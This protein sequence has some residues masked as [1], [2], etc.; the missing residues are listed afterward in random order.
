MRFLFILF[1]LFLGKSSFSQETSWVIP[2][3]PYYS[4]PIEETGLYSIS[5]ETLENNGI[6]VSSVDVSTFQIFG[7]KEEIPLYFVGDGD[8]LFENGE[9]FVFY[10]QKNDSW[11]DKSLYDDPAFLPNPNVS[12]FNDVIQ[13][14][15]TW[16]N[17]IS[18]KRFLEE[19]DIDFSGL[20]QEKN[21]SVQVYLDF[22]DEY[23]EGKPS[24]LGIPTLNYSN[25]EG[26]S[27]PFIKREEKIFSVQTPNIITST[28]IATV[29]YG[30]VNHSNYENEFVATL[31]GKSMTVSIQESDFLKLSEF[32]STSLLKES[33]ELSINNSAVSVS[34]ILGVSYIMVEYPRDFILPDDLY[35]EFFNRDVSGTNLYQFENFLGNRAFVLDIDNETI[36]SNVISAG[37]VQFKLENKGQKIVVA[38]EKALVPVQ[39]LKK[40]AFSDYE[41]T[42]VDY[43]YVIITTEKLKMSTEEYQEFLISRGFNT[44]VVMVEEL[45]HLFGGGIE[46][47]P[48]AIKNFLD[49]I[50]ENWASPPKH[51][52]LIGKSIRHK[53]S[54]KDFFYENLVP[55]YGSPPSDQLYTFSE[56]YSKA[57]AR[58]SIGRIS[59][60]TDEQVRSY[61]GK[62]K[63]Y[64]TTIKSGWKKNIFHFG[65]GNT[66]EEQKEFAEYLEGYKK[67]IENSKYGANVFTQLKTSSD[68]FDNTLSGFLVEKINTGIGL[69]N[70]FGHGSATGFEQNLDDPENYDNQGKYPFMVANSCY[71]G[72]VHL[73]ILSDAEK[74][75]LTPNRGMIGFIATT[76]LSNPSVL[77]NYNDF[78][79]YFFSET[80]FGEPVGDI[81]KEV[82]NTKKTTFPSSVQFA[83]ERV[84]NDLN[85]FSFFSLQGDPSLPLFGAEYPDFSILSKDI[86]LKN[87]SVS[88]TDDSLRLEIMVSNLGLNFQN[89]I[90]IFVERK[91][92]NQNFVQTRTKNLTVSGFSETF[93]I[94]FP[95]N[96]IESLG[97]NSIRVKVEAKEEVVEENEKN[98]EAIKEFIV[99]RGSYYPFYPPSSSIIPNDS[100]SLKVKT[101]FLIPDNQESVFIMELDTSLSFSSNIKRTFYSGYKN[102]GSILSWNV[103]SLIENEVYYWRVKKNIPQEEWKRS[104]FRYE[105]G[106]TGWS[107]TEYGQFSENTGTNISF[108]DVEKNI[109]FSPFSVELSATA[110]FNNVATNNEESVY[111]INGETQG[112]GVGNTVYE[113]RDQLIVAVIDPITLS[114]W[115]N[116]EYFF[117]ENP[118][119]LSGEIYKRYF[120]FFADESKALKNVLTLLRD[121]VSD[122]HY[123]LLYSQNSPRYSTWNSELISYLQTLGFTGLNSGLGDDKAFV[124]FCEKNKTSS[125]EVALN[126]FE[127]VSLKTNLISSSEKGILESSTFIGPAKNWKNL[128]WD[129]PLLSGQNFSLSFVGLDD[130]FQEYEITNIKDITEKKGEIRFMD[131]DEIQNHKLLKMY[132]SLEDAENRIPPSIQELRIEFD[133][134]PYLVLNTKEGLDFRQNYKTESTLLFQSYVENIASAVVDSDV[135]IPLEYSILRPQDGITFPTEN[136]NL[137]GISAKGKKRIS[138]KAFLGGK[139]YLESNVLRVRMKPKNEYFLEQ[140]IY[141]FPFFVEEAIFNPFVNIAFDGKHIENYEPVRKNVDI[142]FFL[143]DPYSLFSNISFYEAEEEKTY[144]SIPLTLIEK[145]GYKN[146]SIIYSYSPKYEDDKT[147]KLKMTAKSIEGDEIFVEK[148]FTTPALF[149]ISNVQNYPNPFWSRT[150]F[151]FEITGNETPTKYDFYIMDLGGKKIKHFENNELG[152]VKVGKNE[153]QLNLETIQTPLGAGI[154]PY[155]II[156]HFS[157]EENNTLRKE[158]FSG[159]M[160]VSY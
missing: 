68:P 16:G 135:E 124:F 137:A 123:I 43:D 85:V 67:Q 146:D 105:E 17:S 119:D 36:F 22:F 13:Y 86:S 134:M 140:E 6:D 37:N 49:I 89:P 100:T 106:I 108:E 3:Q 82:Y 65:G 5:K 19:N 93:F 128:R 70:F 104:S 74:F 84:I 130:S 88:I 136:Q 18:G 94:S 63:E 79:Y 76:S 132:L 126:D 14:Y 53:D 159:K 129:I 15:F 139:T 59:A 30:I 8:N 107:Q 39:N 97:K 153:L 118:I 1:F 116:E 149:S 25:G 147:Y 157:S 61:L 34:G 24:Y 9:Y 28:G 44:L 78:M 148:R 81:L 152:K 121:E 73:N 142:E 92:E 62:A 122:G 103:D 7:R 90:E 69:M 113:K 115:T 27:S 101:D 154:Y 131:S 151:L 120:V 45:Y 127:P 35:L 4:F 48:K 33:L 11:Y 96:G 60:K 114:P 95:I 12:L 83:N 91:I 155:S 80:F 98:N 2:S 102:E 156:I 144:D 38:S 51:V 54:R 117:Q 110:S 99:N 50:S 145:I 23:F 109:S 72:N 64:I 21:I 56:L 31:S 138:T 58:F 133:E 112:L 29:N 158:I 111:S 57:P 46:K 150:R 42:V 52:F 32:V 66:I 160:S 26:W 40:Q 55:T 125:F 143:Y 10:A 20:I 47:H 87:G 141:D 41:N 71:V 75:V 77:D